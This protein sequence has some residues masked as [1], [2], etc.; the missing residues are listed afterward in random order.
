MP[1]IPKDKPQTLSGRRTFGRGARV[2][3]LS[4]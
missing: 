3:T 4:T 2:C 1:E